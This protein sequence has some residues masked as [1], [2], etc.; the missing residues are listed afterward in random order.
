MMRLKPR[1]DDVE[2]ERTMEISTGLLF[3]LNTVLAHGYVKMALKLPATPPASRVRI[4]SPVYE[5]VEASNGSVNS[6]I[7]VDISDGEC[8]EEIEGEGE[9]GAS[10]RSTRRKTMS[11]G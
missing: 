3:L 5:D 9:K 7:G 10:F 2:A 8:C 4:I 6:G 11:N 1:F